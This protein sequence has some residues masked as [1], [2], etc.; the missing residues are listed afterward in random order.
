MKKITIL[1]A[2][3]FTLL[4]SV[5]AEPFSSAEKLVEDFWNKGQ[6]I[7]IVGVGDGNAIRYHNKSSIRMIVLSGNE[8][9]IFYPGANNP[10]YGAAYEINSIKSD[11]MGNIIIDNM[12]FIIPAKNR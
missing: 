5:F 9:T 7:K 1:L 3:M 2:L 11:G 12:G 10:V 8:M 4:F 6:Y